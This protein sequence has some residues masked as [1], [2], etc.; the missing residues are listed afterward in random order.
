MP[1]SA[2]AVRVIARPIQFSSHSGRP[3]AAIRNPELGTVFHF[4]WIPGSALRAAPE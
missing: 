4:D 3:A 2:A 1:I